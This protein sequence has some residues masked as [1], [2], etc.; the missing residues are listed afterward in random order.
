MPATHTFKIFLASPGDT[1]PARAQVV[2]VVQAIN[3]DAL[4]RDH[5][6]IELLHWDNKDQPVP[7]SFLR[8][9]QHDVVKVTGDP[10]GCD[11]VIALFRHEFGSPLPVADFG[12]SPDGDAWTGTEWELHRAVEAARAGQVR[13]V[14]VFRDLTAPALLPNEDKE[15]RRA[16]FA[17]YEAVEDFFAQCRDAKTREIIK[18]YNEH[19][20]LDDF[21]PSFDKRLKEWLK[22]ALQAHQSPAAVALAPPAT[23][24]AKEV[25]TAEQQQLLDILLVDDQPF[26]PALITAAFSA[27][28]RGLRGYLLQRFAAWCRPEQG[29]LD[30]RFVNL[31]LL[32]D[33][34]K[35]FDG[36]RYEAQR[37]PSL[38]QMLAAHP[39]VGAWV[40]LG[41]PG[42]GKSTLLQ[43]HEMQAARAALRALAA[44]ESFPELCIWQRLADYPHSTVDPQAWLEA[45]WRDTYRDLPSLAELARQHRL[46]FLLDGVNEIQAPD[47]EAYRHT[48]RGW[49]DWAA[50]TARRGSAG[51]RPA[52]PFFS[53]RTLEYSQPLSTPALA[54]QQV[55][56]AVWNAEQMQHYCTL[57]LGPDNRLWPQI[58]AD[59]RLR[60][61][62]AL[63]FNLNAQCDLTRELGR[64]AQDRAELFSG[65]TW[66][67]LRHAFTRRELD[68]PDL[69]G[70][71]DRRQLTLDGWWRAHLTELPEEGALVPGLARQAEAMHRAG[72]G[73]EVS[74]PKR[75]V[76]TWFADAG[77]RAAWLKAVQALNLGEVQPNGRF[78]YTHQLWQEYFAAR[79]LRDLPADA[80]TWPDFS[81]P[82]LDPLDQVL[83]I[84]AAKDPLP[85]L[86]VSGW[87]EAV[88]LAVLL[89]DQP[90]RWLAALLPLNLPLAGR[91]AS[92]VRDRLQARAEGRT[93]LQELRTALLQRSRDPAVDLRLR[94]E[95]GLVLGSLGDP[96]YVEGKGPQGHRYLLPARAHWVSQPGGRFLIGGEGGYDDELP[97]TLVETGPFCMA[98]APVTNAEY[99]C[100]VEAGGYEDEQWWQGETSRRWVREGVRNEE[101]IV[102]WTTKLAALRTDFDAGVRRYFPNAT[103]SYIEGTLRTY[104]AWSEA[105]AEQE[106][107]SSFG[108]RTYREPEQWQDAAFNAPTQPVVGLCWFEA[109]A[110]CRWL[111]AQV[112]GT[113]DLQMRM[114]TEAEWEVAAR[115]IKGRRWPWGKPDPDPWQMNADPVHLRRTSPVGVFPGSDSPEGLSDLAGNVWEW[116][117]SLYSET[118]ERDALMTEAPA[119]SARRAVRGGSWSSHSEDCRAGSRLR[120]TAGD[121]SY[122]VGFRFVCCPIQEP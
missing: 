55:R 51:P 32:V 36:E 22:A 119:D 33:R 57:R 21:K 108:A 17:Q 69:L 58:D 4:T 89:S 5:V 72:Q 27:P 14:L 35:D 86:G 59:A 12:L 120:L 74:V 44:G 85:V 97:A 15:K 10:A 19:C 82:P 103:E 34:G 98:F 114:P 65:L 25:L 42:G 63:P 49:A 83:A 46:R 90:A 53:V 95:A 102:L 23:V 115:G 6:H 2:E 81:P 16:R 88:K 111:S 7:C 48:V 24:T 28:V 113:M 91:A 43:H 84:L 56:L 106:L 64:P 75:D 122:N 93:V 71:D 39:D 112:K 79:S 26:N 18:G 68:A 96:R 61:L 100:F 40:F 50:Q 121:R 104:A 77:L 67:R 78:R 45:Q 107:D 94:I 3:T 11:L 66:L 1:A 118:L 54:V 20:G 8:N 116:T 31:D 60:E 29:R 41:D 9:P 30:V 47:A 110:Y 70:E 87:E 52:A 80:A 92:A 37:H 105:E 76:G 62:C 99:R 101:S 117:S 13:D 38:P 73:T 109:Q